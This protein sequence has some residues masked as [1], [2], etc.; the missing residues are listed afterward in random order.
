MNGKNKVVIPTAEFYEEK[1]RKSN[2]Y[3]YPK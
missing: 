3:Y 2:L 1:Q